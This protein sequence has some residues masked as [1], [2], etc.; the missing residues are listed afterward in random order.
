MYYHQLPI[1]IAVSSATDSDF[2][3]NHNGHHHIASE[4]DMDQEYA[5]EDNY[6]YGAKQRQREQCTDHKQYILQ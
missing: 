6:I 3:R 4:I 1:C 2:T 5:L